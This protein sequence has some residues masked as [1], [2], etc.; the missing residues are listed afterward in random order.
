MGLKFVFACYFLNDRKCRDVS[1]QAAS[2]R[3]ANISLVVGT[4]GAVLHFLVFLGREVAHVAS[5]R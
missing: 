3:W 1:C 2:F 5:S 4:P